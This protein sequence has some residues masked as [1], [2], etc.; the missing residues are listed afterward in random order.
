MFGYSLACL[1][2]PVFAL[3]LLVVS[4]PAAFAHHRRHTHSSSRHGGGA[5]Y[6]TFYRDRHGRTASNL[7]PR[8]SWVLLSRGGTSMRVRITDTGCNHF[9]LTPAQFRRFAPLSHGVVR[10]VQWRVLPHK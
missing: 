3:V 4:F 2:T 8:G 5:T 10:G 6:C 1:K 7:A 9:D